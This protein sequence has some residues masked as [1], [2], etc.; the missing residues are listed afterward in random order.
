MRWRDLLVHPQTGVASRGPSLRRG[1]G[2]SSLPSRELI[3]VL[4]DPGAGPG[5]ARRRPASRRADM[6]RAVGARHSTLSESGCTCACPGSD[7]AE[8]AAVVCNCGGGPVEHTMPH[9]AASHRA[10]HAATIRVMIVDGS[11]GAVSN[12]ERWEVDPHDSDGRQTTHEAPH[13]GVDLPMTISLETQRPDLLTLPAPRART[14]HRVE[15]RT[16]RR[17]RHCRDAR[18]L[19]PDGSAGPVRDHRPEDPLGLSNSA[20]AAATSRSRRPASTVS[21]SPNRKGSF[22]PSTPDSPSTWRCE[23]CGPVC[24]T[25]ARA[26]RTSTTSA[27]SPRPDS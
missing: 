17:R 5:T 25:S 4:C 12:D 27:A 6:V 8:P 20:S 15:R 11:V 24:T 1:G 16:H 7:T 22:S 10:G 9:I 2:R 21:A 3:P 14:Q 19:Q 13:V 18:V 26:W 23:Q